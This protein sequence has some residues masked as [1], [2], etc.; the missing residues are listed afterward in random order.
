MEA[1][2][3]I[4]C[5]RSRW[6]SSYRRK[7]CDGNIFYIFLFITLKLHNG[8]VYIN[9]IVPDVVDNGPE[10]LKAEQIVWRE[11]PTTHKGANPATVDRMILTT[12]YEVLF[13]IKVST[14]FFFHP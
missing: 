1:N 13:L 8:D 6:T 2:E 9:K 3:E 7:G 11:H 12:N 14:F 10:N 5:F 4:S